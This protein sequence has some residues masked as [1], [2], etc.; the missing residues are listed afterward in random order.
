MICTIAHLP[1]SYIILQYLAKQERIFFADK[2]CNIF[3]YFL[4]LA[5]LEIQRLVNAGNIEEART[6]Y[7]RVPKISRKLLSA[8]LEGKGYLE[9]AF[10][11]TNDPM[12]RF[13]LSLAINNS[14]Q[15]LK[16]AEEA[17]NSPSGKFMWQTISSYALNQ[18]D[19]ALAIKAIEKSGDPSDIFVMKKIFGLQVDD[20]ENLGIE[21]NF[22]SF[23]ISFL[24]ASPKTAFDA[25]IASEKYP[26]A[27]FF[28]RAWL[29]PE[30][31]QYAIGLWKDHIKKT[32][33]SWNDFSETLMDPSSAPDSFSFLPE[34]ASCDEEVCKKS[35]KGSEPKTAVAVKMNDDE[36][37]FKNEFNLLDSVKNMQIS[38]TDKDNEQHY[39]PKQSP[40]E[41]ILLVNGENNEDDAF[42]EPSCI[43]QKGVSS[44]VDSSSSLENEDILDSFSVSDQ[45][46]HMIS[47]PIEEMVG[48]REDQWMLNN[49]QSPS[50]QN[51]VEDDGYFNAGMDSFPQFHQTPSLQDYSHFTNSPVLKQEIEEEISENL[52]EKESDGFEPFTAISKEKETPPVELQTIPENEDSPIGDV[53][54][55]GMTEQLDVA[56]GD[57]KSKRKSVTWSSELPHMSFSSDSLVDKYLAEYSA[58]H[59]DP[60]SYKDENVDDVFGSPTSHSF[61]ELIDDFDAEDWGSQVRKCGDFKY[62]T[63]TPPLKTACTNIFPTRF[64]QGSCSR[65]LVN[66][67]MM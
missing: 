10:E 55:L 3:S 1:S 54:D 60:S 59:D 45:S 16:I 67:S 35:I 64:R 34:N 14:D 15:A 17:S 46:Q 52:P 12:K 8:F 38:D 2:D 29:G 40:K 26:E 24:N 30:S 42:S 49:Y 11:F 61:N 18:W 19:P 51:F 21:N 53:R 50:K 25:L 33:A 32:Y 20:L 56:A 4:S 66:V 6:H 28:A 31:L 62:H 7:D 13:S 43:I 22:F 65:R 57:S 58:G 63:S 37:A 44:M 5:V 23:L 36:D 9:D 41:D 48:E 47:S 27:A 39:L